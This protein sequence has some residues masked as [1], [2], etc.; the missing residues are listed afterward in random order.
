MY[1]HKLAGS[2]KEGHAVVVGATAADF[3]SSFLF[4]LH[5]PCPVRERQ[6]ALDESILASVAQWCPVNAAQ[7]ALV[8]GMTEAFSHQYGDAVLEVC[9]MLCCAVL[10]YVVLHCAVELAPTS[11][12]YVPLWSLP[13]WLHP[14]SWQ[15]P[16]VG[17][18]Q[19]GTNV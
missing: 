19:S 7:L 12:A 15:R 18:W 2:N 6:G 16:S 10:H 4:C 17:P 13:E 8:P 11:F 1:A 14:P 9:A 5:L 3:P